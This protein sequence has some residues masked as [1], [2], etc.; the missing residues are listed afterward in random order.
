MQ[1]RRSFLKDTIGIAI[2]AGFLN[3]NPAANGANGAATLALIGGRNQGR[4]VALRAVKS[5]RR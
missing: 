2:G 1:E 5:G 4:G 3:L